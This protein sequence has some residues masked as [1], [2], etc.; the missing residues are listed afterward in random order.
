MKI[1]KRG[2]EIFLKMTKFM[3]LSNVKISS[4]IST[5]I[6]KSLL[7]L[8]INERM[9]YKLLFFEVEENRFRTELRQHFFR[10]RVVNIME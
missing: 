1:S 8:Q 5:P 9:V 2:F 4:C 6:V 7:W 3:K 10:E